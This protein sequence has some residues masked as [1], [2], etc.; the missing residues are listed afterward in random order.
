MACR[1]GA[2]SQER[3]FRISHCKFNQLAGGRFISASRTATCRVTPDNPMG[4]IFTRRQCCASVRCRSFFVT[5]VQFPQL[6]SD[7]CE[8]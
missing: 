7:K 2:A 3:F 4:W 1:P 5:T 8:D 6:H